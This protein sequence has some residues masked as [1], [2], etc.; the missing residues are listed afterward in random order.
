[1]LCF[2][3]GSNLVLNIKNNNY[4]LPLQVHDSHIMCRVGHEGYV[5]TSTPKPCNR[6]V[7]YDHSILSF[8]DVEVLDYNDHDG[9]SDEDEGIGDKYG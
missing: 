5:Y 2:N 9:D 4:N 1:M 7:N 3:I 6:S 8:V